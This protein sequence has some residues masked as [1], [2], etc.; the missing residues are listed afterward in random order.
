MIEYA[1]HGD[2]SPDILAQ[3][4]AFRRPGVNAVP[5]T[6]TG[7]ADPSRRLQ[8]ARAR[9]KLDALEKE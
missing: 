4:R 2:R 3:A 7:P 9:V 1:V 8:T 5:R 6:R